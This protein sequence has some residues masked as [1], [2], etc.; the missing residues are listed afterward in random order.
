M[1]LA[2]VSTATSPLWF[3]TRATGLTAMVLLTVSVVLGILTS[4]RFARPAWPR[5][6]TVGLH[7][8]LSLLVVTFTGLHVLTTVADPYASI[9][10]VSAVIP[11]TS[12]Y[13]PIWLALG[14]VAFDLLLAVF[15][16]SLLRVRLGVR[17]WRIVHWASYLCWPVALIH[18]LGTGTDGA[19]KWVLAVTAACAL[20]VVAA[21][22]WRLAV[23]WP[24]HAALR[25]AAAAAAVL[26]VFGT[27]AWLR[28]GPM[29][30][31]WARR[32]GTPA[33]LLARNAGAGGVG[34]LSSGSSALPSVPFQ[35]AVAGTATITNGPGSGDQTVTLDMT[36]GTVARLRVVVSGPA[37]Q[38][39]VEMTSSEVSLGPPAAPAQYTGKLVTLNGTSMQAIVTGNGKRLAL[40][41]NLTQS[42]SSVSGTMAAATAPAAGSGREGE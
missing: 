40:T 41:I 12:A 10:V 33:A 37:V 32:A 3:A 30:P 38:G 18:G 22:V 1:P 25:M 34:T 36:S 14:A 26:V 8:N 27:L 16:T 6:I 11:F 15:I 28:A 13:R 2:A 23:G 17:T 19:A 39:G 24:R 42:G 31:G 7:R 35:I 29:R 4:V 9:S 21:G 5:Y 20:A